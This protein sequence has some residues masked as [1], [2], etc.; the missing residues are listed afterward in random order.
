MGRGSHQDGSS[1][2]SQAY[3][4]SPLR[5]AIL[6]QWKICAGG[7]DLRKQGWGCGSVVGLLPSVH[8]ALGSISS[9][10]GEKK[11]GKGKV[12][13]PALAGNLVVLMPEH[14]VFRA[15]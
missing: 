13:F 3:L 6:K 11:M 4:L 5:K 1:L 2:I 9:S 7:K 8:K 10:G 14:K 15:L 12:T